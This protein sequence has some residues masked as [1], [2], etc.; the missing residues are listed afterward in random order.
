MIAESAIAV[1]LSRLPIEIESLSWN[2]G[3]GTSIEED[4]RHIREADLVVF[5]N[6]EALDF[7]FTNLRAREYEQ[8]T[9]QHF[10]EVPM[11]VI[12]GIR[13][14]KVIHR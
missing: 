14:Y 3:Y 10:G 2:A 5:Q 9:Q 7:P 13:I 8:Y 1:S 11:K 6:K 12:N 4:L